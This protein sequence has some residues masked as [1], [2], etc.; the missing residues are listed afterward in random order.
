MSGASALIKS[1]LAKKYWMA[2]TG[3]FLCFF[4][5]VHLAGNLTLLAG[6]SARAGFN[7]YTKFMTSFVP[8][9]VASY[10]TYLGILFHAVDGLLLT[11]K[12]RKARPVKY[13]YEK[14]QVNSIWSSRNMGVLG[15]AIFVFIVLHMGNFW[16]RYKFTT[17][18]TDVDG[19][20]DMYG[21]V[22]ESFKMEW[23]VGLYV[24]CMAALAFHLYHGFWSAFQT[25]G[26]NHPKY[27]P[28]IKKLGFGFSILI[29]LGF[30]IIPIAVYVMNL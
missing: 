4:L 5:I 22:V 23:Y 25:L 15:T 20:F 12:N 6:D 14:P 17:L 28:A 21:V 30:A 13:A 29:P 1:S 19:N 7:A 27:T 24:L 2:L 26:V 10:I 11:L 18:P 9:K 16:F 8:I 3:L